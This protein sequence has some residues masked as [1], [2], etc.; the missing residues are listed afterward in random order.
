M[1]LRSIVAVLAVMFAIPLVAQ[2][3]DAGS[4]PEWFPDLDFDCSREARPDGVVPPTSMPYY[5]EDP[6][7]T[8]EI[9]THLLWHD[10]PWDSVFRG[11]EI[12]VLAV[13]ARL[14]ITDRLAFIATKDGYAWLNPGKHSQ[15]RKDQGLFDLAA[16]FKY[17]LIRD[18]ESG[19]TLTPALRFVIPSGTKDVLAGYGRGAIIP[20]ASAALPLGPLNT[21][22]SFGAYQPFDTSRE[23]AYLFY[24]LHVSTP[25]LKV[26]VPFAELNGTTWTRSGSG[27]NLIGT[28]SFGPVSL[29]TAQTV[30]HGAGVT[31]NRSFEGA[32]AVNLGS[33]RVAGN[34]LMTLALGGRIPITKQ[35]SLAGYYEFP[36]TRREDIFE[37]RIG[38]NA[39][40]EF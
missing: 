1:T 16:G 29:S 30:L 36:V 20:S 40:Y 17:A 23:S 27:R 31:A 19:F 38:V 34:T 7:I 33:A 22:G 12:W 2:A 26:L 25:L 9:S 28:K 6:F 3:E 18:E 24:N 4:C 15:I 8:T 14:A 10:F 35:A 39:V 5:F 37:Q 32:D 11:G 13:Q 21:I